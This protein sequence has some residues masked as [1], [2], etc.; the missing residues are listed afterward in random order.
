MNKTPAEVLQVPPNSQQAE[1]AVLGSILIGGAPIVE[2]CAGWIRR[3]KAFYQKLHQQIWDAIIEEYR[4][5]NPIDIITVSQKVKDMYNE[6]ESYYISGL[7]ESVPTTA[8]VETY[9]R[10]VWEKYIQRKN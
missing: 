7:A 6:S 4:S 8:N 1:E 2:K 10:M 5:H 3:S 9:A